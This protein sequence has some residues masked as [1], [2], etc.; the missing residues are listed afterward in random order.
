MI[1]LIAKELN[2]LV[3]ELFIKCCSCRLSR[4]NNRIFGSIS[5]LNFLFKIEPTYNNRSDN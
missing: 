1:I 3:L 5:I 4:F 2:R